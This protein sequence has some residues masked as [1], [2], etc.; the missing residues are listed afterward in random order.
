MNLGAIPVRV[1]VADHPEVVWCS[2]IDPARAVLLNVP[3]PETGRRFKDLVL[4]DGEPRGVRRL[5]GVELSVV[6]ELAVLTPSS[7]Q[8]WCVTVEAR[9]LEDRDALL[10]SLKHGD[11]AAEDWTDSLQF[12][13]KSC[14]EGSTVP[15][16]HAHASPDDGPWRV[17][18]SFGVAVHSEHDLNPLAAW[19]R[20]GRGRSYGSPERAL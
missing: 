14:S 10:A 16:N 7:F 5:E 20:A 2:R 17:E 4:H 3:T 18:R 13:C 6:D 9:S 12:Y 15:E 1:A 8:T 11:G 19:A